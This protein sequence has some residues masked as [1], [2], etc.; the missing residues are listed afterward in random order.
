MKVLFVLFRKPGLS[1]EQCL[2]EWSRERH[3]SIV[4]KTPGLTR[5]IQNHV[6]TPPSEATP[7]GI[8]ELWFD[9]AAAMESAEMAAAVED[10]RRFL[11]MERSYAVV[12]VERRVL[13]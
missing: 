6:G 12:V 1:H 7:D 10:A 3:T 4:R 2:T 11:D 5:W 13:G 8:G 9:S